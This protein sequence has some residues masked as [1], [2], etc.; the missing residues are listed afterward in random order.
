MLANVLQY[1][2]DVF[3]KYCELI[4][5]TTMMFCD[6]VDYKSQNLNGDINVL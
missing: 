4:L 3:V 6:V 5:I 1:V 2:L